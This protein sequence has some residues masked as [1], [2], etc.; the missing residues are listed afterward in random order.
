MIVGRYTAII[1]FRKKCLAEEKLQPDCTR[2][3]LGCLCV[4][5]VLIAGSRPVSRP[6]ARIPLP[7]SP[8]AY[9]RVDQDDIMPQKIT[10]FDGT[11][12]TKFAVYNDKNG[13]LNSL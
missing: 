1:T 12:P 8:G 13:V 9:A 10:G 11:V 4:I 6:P 5:L 7:C 2:R 3:R